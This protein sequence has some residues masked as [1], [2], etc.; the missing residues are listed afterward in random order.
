MSKQSSGGKSGTESQ[1]SAGTVTQFQKYSIQTVAREQLKNAPYNPRVI[2]DKA[3]KKLRKVIQKHGLIEPIVWNKRTGNIVG[4]HQRIS[5]LDTLESN[6]NYY[7]EVAVVDL[8]E[9]KE[10]EAN[11]ALNNSESQGVF[12]IEKLSV[13]FK[14]NQLDL[15]STGFD[16]ADIFQMFGENPVDTPNIDLDAM[17]DQLADLRQR[18]KAVHEMLDNANDVNYFS[19]LV[20]KDDKARLRFTERFGITDNRYIDGASIAEALNI[21]IVTPL[22]SENMEEEDEDGGDE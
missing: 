19:V 16:M 12:D 2:D 8:E 7:I 6:K 14:G 1:P 11:I 22:E 20:F 10:M 17:A 18:T 21:D 15:E 13:M 5:I 3:K 4:G 9:K